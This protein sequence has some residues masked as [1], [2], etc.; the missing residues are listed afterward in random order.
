MNSKTKNIE[1]EQKSSKNQT[2]QPQNKISDQEIMATYCKN[3]EKIL[4]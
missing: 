2:N 3:L 1:K 4:N